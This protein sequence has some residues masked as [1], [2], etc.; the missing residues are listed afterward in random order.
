VFTHL[1]GCVSVGSEI[2]MV[3]E[4]YFPETSVSSG[5]IVT[6][7]AKG[8]VKQE[9]LMPVPRGKL[10]S[11]RVMPNNE[12]VLSAIS[13]AS[14]SGPTHEAR[15]ITRISSNGDVKAQTIFPS[16]VTQAL[17]T[18]SDPFVYLVPWTSKKGELSVLDENLKQVSQTK[19]VVELIITKRAFYLPDHSLVLFGGQ[20]YHGNS[21]TA[22]I[23]L[24]SPD[25]RKKTVLIIEPALASN[26]I[27]DAVPTGVVGEF[28]AVRPVWPMSEMGRS[29]KR[30]GVA[31][32]FVKI[33]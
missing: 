28:V 20:Q 6:L 24:I 7:D 26:T 29:D 23:A 10:E 32:S 18:F 2:L 19:G 16:S 17:T 13:W 12:V 21:F 33:K 5:W 31:L 3:G 15:L 22:S 1:N 4:T 8:S 14:D 27:V 9:R 25:L 30:L 11:I